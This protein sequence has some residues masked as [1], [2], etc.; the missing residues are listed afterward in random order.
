MLTSEAMRRPGDDFAAWADFK[1]WMDIAFA[2][3][4]KAGRDAVHAGD[5]GALAAIEGGQVP[6][7][8]GYDYA[9]LAHSVD[10]MELFDYGGTVD[11]VRSLNPKIAILTT[12]FEGGEREEHRV[13]REA[14]RGNRGLILW[15]PKGDF[16]ADDGAPGGRG[17][18]A[19]PYFTEL[20]DGLGALLIGSRTEWDPVAILYSPASLRIQWMLDHRHDGAAWVERDAAAEYEDNAVRAALRGYQQSLARAG[21][22]YRF[23]SP[24]TL[25]DG[26]LRKQG[27]RLLVLPHAIALSVAE[28]R[29]IRRFVRSGGTLLADTE[30]GVSD[31]HGRRLPRPPLADLFAAHRFGHGTVIELPLPP[32]GTGLR[33]RAALLPEWQ[34]QHHRAPAPPSR[35]RSRSRRRGVRRDDDPALARPAFRL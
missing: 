30:P 21:I 12:S 3:A 31:E 2:R 32:F 25:G 28:A 11:I 17:S 16:V 33:Y 5:N 20:R 26:A 34:G 19:R 9:H 18:A 8:G 22:Q 24:E 27:T 35:G 23:L 14:L 29:E 10:V 1:A 4:L 13:W 6:G 15:D 7:W